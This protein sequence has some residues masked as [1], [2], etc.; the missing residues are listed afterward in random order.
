VSACPRCGEENVERARF[1]STCGAPLARAPEDQAQVRKTVT[2]LFCDVTGSTSLGERQDPEALRQAMSRYFDE[3]RAV[4]ER[5]GASVEKF[6]GD[7]VMAVFGVPKLHEDDALRA[8]RAAL[9]MQSALAN[10]NDELERSWGFRLAIRIGLNTGEVVAGDPSAGQTFV[11]GDAVNVANRLEQ[12]AEPGDVLI[13]EPTF[14]LVKGSVSAQPVGLVELKGRSE[15]V[16][17]FRLVA[18]AGVAELE[19]RLESPLVGRSRDR[20]VLEGAFEHAVGERTCHLVT[21]LGTPGV[22]KSRLVAELIGEV[23]GQAAVLTGRCLPYGDGITFWPVTELIRQAAGLTGDEPVGA[24]RTALETML[25]G[26]AEPRVVERLLELV[27]VAPVPAGSEETFWAVRRFLETL[28]ARRPLV[29]VFDDIHWAEPTLLDLIEHVADWSRGVPLLLACMARPELLDLRPTWGGGKLNATSIML[30]RLPRADCERLIAN[31]LDGELEPEL[32]LQVIET[33]EGNPFFIEEMLSMLVEDGAVRME[34]GRWVAGA[35]LEH[36]AVPPTIQ[37]LLGARLDRLGAD[38]RAVVARAAVEGKVFHQDA[39]LELSPPDAVAEVEAALTTLVRKELIRAEPVTP[40]GRPAFRFRHILIRDAAY[41]AI[42]KQLRAE[43]HER[44]ANWVERRSDGRGPEREEISAYHLEQAFGYLEQLGSVDERTRALAARAAERLAAAGRRALVRH[45]MPAAAALLGRAAALPAPDEGRRLGLLPDLGV[46]L[47]ET[48][49]LLDADVVLAEAVDG[50]AA[51]GDQA[52]AARA[53]I[54]RSLVRLFTGDELDDL[55]RVGEHAIGVFAGAADDLGVARAWYLL[56]QTHWLRCHYGEVQATLERAIAHAQR[57]GDA[58]EEARNRWR[59]AAALALGPTPAD[60]AIE[61]CLEILASAPENRMLEGHV[62]AT[63]ALPLAMVGRFEEARER[64]L[65]SRRVFEELGLTF[66]IAGLSVYA[67]AV[68]LLAD[69]PG[70]AERILGAAYAVL[71]RAGERSG[72]ST[73]AALLARALS[74]QGRD[75]EAERYTVASEEA[76]WP[77]DVSSQ[78]L[79]RAERAR[80]LAGRGDLE[81][82]DALVVEADRLAAQTDALNMRADVKVDLAELHQRAGRPEATAALE[83][84]LALYERKGNLVAAQRAQS[85]L[86]QAAGGR[87]HV[88]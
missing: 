85:L 35:E 71:E 61:H 40:G 55:Q 44:F 81:S 52:L 25:A 17:A 32:R 70:A 88:T 75:E 29:V 66:H 27:A 45:D 47:R 86:A 19:R 42:P 4:L 53:E 36:I 43:L 60:A 68:E 80:V 16:T 76:A 58:R 79:W 33:A 37:A 82:A 22:G 39:V 48:G 8:V 87:A 20:A 30:E 64:A 1:C 13:G 51:M 83:E 78:V 67:G 41:E 77:N 62:S 5:H 56:A 49:R 50:A 18:A 69:D 6:I 15:P 24:V 21:V 10:L 38:E 34:N 14:R 7:A 9:D 26:E 31:L 84:A 63:L 11:T 65:Q 3:M 73:H 59:L 28:A 23:G 54:E 57:A 46:A 72:R 2:V 12:A 74:A